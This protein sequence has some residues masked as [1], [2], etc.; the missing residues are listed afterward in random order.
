[1]TVQTKTADTLMKDSVLLSGSANRPLAEAVA[2][3]LG[4][5]PGGCCVERFPDGELGVELLAPVR[6]REVYVVQPTSPPVNDN[7]VELLAFA[8]ACRRASAARV[9]AIVPYFGYARAD[10]RGTRRAA[11]TASLVALLLQTAGIE[12]LLTFD[13][14][15]PQV[16]GFFQH[17]VDNLTAVPRLCDA[18][19]DHLPRNAVVVSPDAG[20]VPMATAYARALDLP[21][22]V[23][24]KQRTSGTDTAV[25]HIVGEVKGHPCLIVDDMISTGGTIAK[26]VVALLKAGARRN[27]MVAATHGLFV[28]AARRTLSHPAIRGIFVT[29]TVRPRKLKWP[30]LHVVPVAPAIAEAIRRFAAHGSLLDVR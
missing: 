9:T 21:L 17:P 27:I 8:D 25:T 26:S 15:T 5:E 19:K 11:I 2:R 23:M 14:H 3:D 29:D 13:L 12:Q 6:R 30:E 10:R 7:L 28:G 16:E 22:V 4:I 1:M 24:H 18:V 20:R